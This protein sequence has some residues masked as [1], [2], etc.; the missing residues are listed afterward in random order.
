M[1]GPSVDLELPA[2][3][4]TE[5][6]ERLLNERFRRISS[7]LGVSSGT[8]PSSP[9]AS[10]GS[11]TSDLFL[12]VPGTLAIRSNAAPLATFSRDRTITGLVALV[13]RAPAGGAVT[14]RLLVEGVA[15][16]SIVIAAGAISATA[17]V[18]SYVAPANGLLTLDIVGV[19]STFPGADLTVRVLFA[20]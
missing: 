12:A 15:A 13:K 7:L 19:G 11:S 4:N 16:D 8:T 3:Y 17:A 6:L 9:A 10:G 2:W 5:E 14:L 20:V 18:G 1:R